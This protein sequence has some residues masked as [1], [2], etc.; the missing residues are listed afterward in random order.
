M[1]QSVKLTLRLPPLLHERLCQ[2]AREE[3]QSLNKIIVEALW[4]DLV[5]VTSYPESGRERALRVIRESGLW[6]PL[7]REWQAEI[8]QAPKLTHAELREQ[9]KGVPPL[10]KLI[11]EDREPR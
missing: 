4:Q 5:D 1:R 8:E 2:R 7:G 11:I 9:L 6:E 10:S 3:D